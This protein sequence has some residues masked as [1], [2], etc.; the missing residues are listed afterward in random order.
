M[1]EYI[2]Q[3]V[4][5]VFRSIL[6]LTVCNIFHGLTTI[7]TI[8]VVSPIYVQAKIGDYVLAKLPHLI[9]SLDINE[10]KCVGIRSR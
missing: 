4:T 10:A 7:L 3:C 9:K 8:L 6:W 5:Q 2:Y 1:R